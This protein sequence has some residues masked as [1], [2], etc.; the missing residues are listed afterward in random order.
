MSETVRTWLPRLTRF[1]TELIEELPHAR[2]IDILTI[3]TRT[4]AHVQAFASLRPA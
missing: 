2:G 1:I 4:T 3:A